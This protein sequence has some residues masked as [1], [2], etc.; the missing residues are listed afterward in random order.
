MLKSLGVPQRLY[1]VSGVDMMFKKIQSEL[2][3]CFH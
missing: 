1:S 3:Y 2:D